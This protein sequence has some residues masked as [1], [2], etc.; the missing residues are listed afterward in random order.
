[1]FRISKT[2]P[3]LCLPLLLTLL[4]EEFTK[5]PIGTVSA[6][7]AGPSLALD[8]GYR[9]AAVRWGKRRSPATGVTETQF[10]VLL[11][12]DGSKSSLIRTFVGGSQQPAVSIPE[13]AGNQRFTDLHLVD[14]VR[15][16]FA[17]PS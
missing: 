6:A 1:M 11:V 5:F 3:L 12:N 7:I 10:G 14:F 4:V 16:E 9:V 8:P 17:H 13:R 15:G 2:T